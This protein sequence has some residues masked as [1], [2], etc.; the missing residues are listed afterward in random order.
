ME[1]LDNSNDQAIEEAFN[2][3]IGRLF[4]LGR[5]VLIIIGSL[6]AA[7]VGYQAYVHLLNSKLIKN[8]QVLNELNLL[9]ICLELV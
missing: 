8:M 6:I 5:S 9:F 4:T 3:Y 7:V 2:T 1:L